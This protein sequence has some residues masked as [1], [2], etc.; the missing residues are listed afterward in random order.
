MKNIIVYLILLFLSVGNIFSAT[1]QQQNDLYLTYIELHY[2]LAQEQQRLYKIPASITLAQG[3]LESAAGKSQLAIKAR[4]HFG[5]KCHEWEGAKISYKGSCYRK[6][7]DVA[8]SY[9]DHSMFLLR[10]RYKSL[11]ELDITDYKGWAKGLKRLGYAEDPQY[12]SKLIHIIELY[13]LNKYVTQD[14]LEKNNPYRGKPDF[15]GR[16]VYKAWGMLY[17]EAREGDTYQSIADDMGFTAKELAKYNEQA[18]H[19][20]L[21]IGEIVYLEKK[22]RMAAEGCGEHIVRSGETFHSVSQLYGIEYRRLA[23][24][25]RMPFTASIEKGMVLKLR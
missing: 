4:N 16:Q 24:R 20:P 8:Q 17:V 18:I 9:H 3:L 15:A 14:E 21:K 13:D 19:T 1:A 2:R 7:K 22:R 12:A 11:Y 25:N 6:Y 10:S 23:R 5:I